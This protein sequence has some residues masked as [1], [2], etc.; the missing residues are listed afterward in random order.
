MSV[1][2]HRQLAEEMELYCLNEDIGAGLPLWLPAGAALRAALEDYIRDLEHRAGYERVLSPHLGKAVLYESSGHLRH[3]RADMFPPLRDGGDEFYLK[4]MN[5]PHHHEVYRHRPRSYRELPLRLAE[6]G[7]V[8]RNEN[9]GSLRGLARVRG[10]CQN[11][12]HIYLAPEDARAELHRVLDLFDRAHADLGLRERRF[13]LSCGDPA[14]AD[15]EGAVADWV[16]AEELLRSV[17]LERGRPFFEAPGEAAFYGPKIDV[18]MKLGGGEESV[19]SVQLDFLSAE[20]FDL[21]YAAADG[22]LRRPWILHRAP[23]GSFERIVAVLLEAHAGRLPD[24]LQPVQILL[25]PVREE[26]RAF[27]ADW[28][29]RLRSAGLRAQ[30]D[31][32]E[33]R[34]A[35]RL[36]LAHRLRPVLFAVI[37]DQEVAGGFWGLQSRDSRM[38][39]PAP[40]VLEVCAR[41]F[42]RPLR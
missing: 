37:G 36:A 39:V 33:G 1:F 5:C 10:L 12:A 3:Y 34:L 25:I 30:V 26:H 15:F 38:E 8:Y 29:S 2:D 24:W 27:A 42:A 22:S 31:R 13:R 17:L 21:K 16:A 7:H 28:E 6:C 11:D 40:Q 9:G 20:R 32:R 4:P 14:R 19:A 35:K 18:Q 23:L 41:R